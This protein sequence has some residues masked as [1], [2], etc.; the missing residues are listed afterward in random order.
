MSPN[1]SLGVKLDINPCLIFRE[2][3]W[4]GDEPGAAV[5]SCKKSKEEGQFALEMM[6]L[7]L[8]DALQRN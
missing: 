5:T 7:S 4:D 2:T 6:V 8:T 3:G 1:A